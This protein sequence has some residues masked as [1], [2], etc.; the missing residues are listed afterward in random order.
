[1]TVTAVQRLARGQGDKVVPDVADYDAGISDGWQEAEH[2][3]ALIGTE[4]VAGFWEGEPGWVAFE[5]WPYN[6]ICVIL[7]GRVAIEDD[8]GERVEF[9]PGE[10]FMVPVGF[11]GIWHTLETTEKIFVGVVPDAAAKDSTA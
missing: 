6:E 4:S 1:M 11:K 8:Q 10:S 2:R 7:K 5:S 9:G 3:A